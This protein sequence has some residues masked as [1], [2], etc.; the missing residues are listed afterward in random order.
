MLEVR[1]GEKNKELKR[2]RRGDIAL[3]YQ[4]IRYA[5]PMHRAIGSPHALEC[6]IANLLGH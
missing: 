6:A 2:K 4:G 1:L 5:A 3:Y